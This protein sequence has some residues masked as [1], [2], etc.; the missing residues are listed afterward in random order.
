MP[1]NQTDA[2]N[3]R[4]KMIGEHLSGDHGPA[5][6]ARRYG[7]SRK[8]V[9][10]WI[11]RYELEGVEGLKERSSAPHH[12]PNATHQE[13]VDE[14]LRLKAQWPH[15]GAPKLLARLQREMK[16][17]ACPAES[18]ISEILKRHGLSNPRQKRRHAVPSSQPLAHASEPNAVWCVDF[19]GWFRTGDGSKC[20]P[21]TLTDAY[22]RYLLRCQGLGESTGHL[23]V[24][25]IMI[26]AFREHGMPWAIR[27][28]N[29][30]PFATST[31]GGLSKLSV[32]WLRLGIKVERIEP[33]KPQQNGRH[34]R[35]H[36]TLEQHTA[37]PPA[38]TLAAQQR[39]FEQFRCEYNQHRPHEALGQDTPAQHYEPSSREYP[40]RLP[41]ARE[42]PDDWQRRR[43]RSSGSMKWKGHQVTVNLALAEQYVGLQPVDEGRWAVWFQDLELGIF[44]ERTMEVQS[45]KSIR[46]QT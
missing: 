43:V 45:H 30:P 5:E 31:L 37:A 33:G 21:L 22:S 26:S 39:R 14:I 17:G 9:Y 32:W 41:A 18:T 46:S 27:S 6:L 12:H 10:E 3:E 11:A 25:P 16:V 15:W 4:L 20:S 44:D 42:F 36:R 19:K 8:T 35:F 13:V 28:D 38:S 1:W 29:G 34:E 2:M 40:S 24:Q 7:V 23:L